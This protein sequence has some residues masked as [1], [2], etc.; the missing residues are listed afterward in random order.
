MTPEPP[1]PPE[2]WDQVPP[3]ARVALLAVLQQH[4]ARIALLEQQ[5]RDLQEQL[6]RNST[7]SSRPPSS[8]LPSVKRP[9]PRPP[10]GRT[11]GAQPGHPL[12][13]APPLEPT[14]IESLRPAACSRCGF[15]LAGDDPAP[16]RHQVIDLPPITPEV[17]EYRLHG[18]CCPHC[19][20]RTRATLPP[21]VPTGRY[22]PR[23]QAAL[24]LLTG[25]YRLSKRHVEGLCADL[26]GVPIS[27]G[28]VCALE[29]QTAA[30]LGP[31]VSELRAHV[32][33]QPANVDETGWPQG[34][35]RCWLWVVATA[36]ATVYHITASRAGSVVR[37]L[38]GPL[39]RQVVTS[40]RFSAY[41]WLPLARRQLC[42]AHLLRDFQAMVDRG[43]SGAPVGRMLLGWAE[44]VFGWW[45]RVRDGTLSRASFRRYLAP[46]RA[47]FREDLEAGAAC[48]CARTAAVCRELLAVE[49]ALWTF[50]RVEG[51]EPTNNAAERALRHAVCWRKTSY[52]TDSPTGSRFVERVLTAV[53]T[54]RQQGRNVLDFLTDCC[55][56]A[57]VTGAPSLLPQPAR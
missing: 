2:L 39:H 10:S 33:G 42:W 11:K 48:A 9:P 40:D 43:N 25:A 20:T 51:V 21:G 47:C 26:L 15:L 13:R 14:R 19:G 1:I 54:C 16:L 22:G 30:A 8:D 5:V 41:S 28:Q 27:P 56:A 3:A 34:G 35:R 46:V 53:A 57:G 52:G 36:A 55:H 44:C 45:P 18:L 38:L 37:D 4:Q 7:N 31:V 32:Q 23:L 50:A 6:A 12:F 24:A 49:P 29:Q 17:T